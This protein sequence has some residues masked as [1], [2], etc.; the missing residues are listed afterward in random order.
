MNSIIE[1]QVDT[2][3]EKGKLFFDKE[4]K[5]FIEFNYEQKV[6]CQK[7]YDENR[8]KIIDT[9]I[10]INKD[11]PEYFDLD[12]ELE[13]DNYF[14]C[15][16]KPNSKKDK[17]KYMPANIQLKINLTEEIYNTLINC[18]KNQASLCFFYKN[19]AKTFQFL[20]HIQKTSVAQCLDNFLRT[21]D[22]WKWL[23]ASTPQTF[24]QQ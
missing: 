2:K 24:Y 16:N 17:N 18:D 15:W 23:V 5:T 6:T 9:I 22:F 3:I 1:E 14:F 4:L 11:L 21:H 12:M 7:I 19:T 20:F 13:E 10:K 8:I